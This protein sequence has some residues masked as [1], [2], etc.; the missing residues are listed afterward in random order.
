MLMH[1]SLD[2]RH[3]SCKKAAGCDSPPGH[4]PRDAAIRGCQTL[5]AGERPDPLLAKRR[6]RVSSR[7]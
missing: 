2:L 1:L 3:V 6:I 4:K 7:R 5:V